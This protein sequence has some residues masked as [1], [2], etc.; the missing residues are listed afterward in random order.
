MK[1]IACLILTFCSIQFLFSQSITQ[2]SLLRRIATLE[3]TVQAQNETVK[4]LKGVEQL[5]KDFPELASS[6]IYFVAKKFG[7]GIL[8]FIG[9][10][11]L[12]FWI[13][14]SVHDF[15]Y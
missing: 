5:A 7:F 9:S 14:K 2:D 4:N 1:K 13:I 15:Q 8:L 12:V 3:T 10:L 11:V 6:P